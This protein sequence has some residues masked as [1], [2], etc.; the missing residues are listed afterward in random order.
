LQ[1]TCSGERN[2]K[3]INH[4][5]AIEIII[6]NPLYNSSHAHRPKDIN[7]NTEEETE[8]YYM[9]VDIF[10]LEFDKDTK[11]LINEAEK[12]LQAMRDDKILI[13]RRRFQPGLIF[14]KDLELRS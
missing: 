1:S 8:R 12:Y 6:K 14:G 11:T 9:S 2:V 10:C 3:K 5:G 7:I 13:R 4:P